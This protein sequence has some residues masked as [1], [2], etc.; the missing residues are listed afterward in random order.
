MKRHEHNTRLTPEKRQHGG[1]R[2]GAGKPAGQEN[3]NPN[4]AA[5]AATARQQRRAH[6]EKMVDCS[7]QQQELAN[8]EG[9]SWSY[10]ECKL[11]LTLVFGL[12]LQYGETPTD[13]L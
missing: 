7:H 4:K 13:A 12:I 9:R 3:H 1:H 11:I 10:E 6:Q 2:E 5:A 8:A